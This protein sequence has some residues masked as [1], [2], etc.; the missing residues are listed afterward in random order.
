M[1]SRVSPSFAALLLASLPLLSSASSADWPTGGIRVST[2]YS[3]K[4]SPCVGS[5]GAGGAFVAWSEQSGPDRLVRAQH[6]R[7]DG[8][9]APGWPSD[10]ILV[11]PRW[12]S[13]TT[14]PSSPTARA[15]PTSH[16]TRR[17]SMAGWEWLT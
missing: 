1:R 13:T 5:D 12:V 17:T 15:E 14:S 3:A 7:R 10:G 8:T 16:G 6:L 4:F 2:S 11:S 9:V